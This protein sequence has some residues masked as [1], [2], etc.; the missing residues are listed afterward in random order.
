MQTSSLKGIPRACACWR[1]GSNRNGYGGELAIEYTVQAGNTLSEIAAQNNLSET[2]FVVKE[3]DQPCTYGIRWFTPVDEIDL[4]GHCTF[5]SAYILFRFFEPGETVIHFNALMCGY[6]LIV[7]KQGETLTM[8]FPATPPVPYQYADYMG[9]ALGAVPSEVWKTDRDLL[10]VFDSDRTVAELTPDFQKIKAFPVGLSCY[11]PARSSDP[12]F[13][14]VA[15]AFWPKIHVN[16][17]PVC[18]S[19]HTTLMPFWQ[20]RLQK[21]RIVSRNLSS[22]GGTVI[23]QRAGDRVKLSGQG[24]LYLTGHILTDEEP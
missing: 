20:E 14:I 4:C 17:D 16:E 12:A 19:M 23:C 8:V 22:R 2:G 21:D 15:R 24:K 5:G 7:E 11:V 10:M 18:G 6:H 13:D 9:D 3:S 1:I